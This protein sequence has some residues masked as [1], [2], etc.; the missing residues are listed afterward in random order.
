M[1]PYQK[2]RSQCCNSPSGCEITERELSSDACPMEFTCCLEWFPGRNLAIHAL[3]GTDCWHC[4]W[5]GHC[6]V[7]LV[8]GSK[9]GVR[10]ERVNTVPCRRMW[11]TALLPTPAAMLSRLDELAIFRRDSFSLK[12]AFILTLSSILFEPDA[13]LLTAELKDWCFYFCLR[14]LGAD[15]QTLKSNLH[16]IGLKISATRKHNHFWPDKRTSHASLKS[17]FL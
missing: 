10:Y 17:L 1:K 15:R 14:F 3:E 11:Q 16:Q 8:K 13:I 5:G 6:C 12:N 2:L 7:V 4:T 9:H